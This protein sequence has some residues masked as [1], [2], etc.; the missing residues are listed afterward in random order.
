MSFLQYIINICIFLP[1]LLGLFLLVTKLSSNQ[2]IKSNNRK[3]VKILEKTIIAKDTYSLVMKIG[4][5]GYVGI[6]SPTGFQ[7]VKELN[8]NELL[9]FES[10]SNYIQNTDYIAKATPLLK[11][12][13][14]QMKLLLKKIIKEKN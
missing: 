1:L 8:K 11:E 3:Y 5:E 10:T 14:E 2:Y 6:S 9:A 4:E 12:K 7:M 13:L